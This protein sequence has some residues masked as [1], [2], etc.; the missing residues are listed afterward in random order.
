MSAYLYL[1]SA[2]PERLIISGLTNLILALA[3]FVGLSSLTV[4][5]FA[6]GVISVLFLIICTPL[7]AKWLPAELS[8]LRKRKPWLCV[9]WLAVSIVCVIQ[10]SRLSVFMMNPALPQ[11]SLFPGDTW[12]EQHCCLTAYNEGANLS[13]AGE[14]NI[15]DYGHYNHKQNGFNVDLYHYPP[16]FLLLPLTLQSITGGNF[17]LLRML[18]FSISLLCLMAAIILI[19]YSLEH[20]GKMRMIGMAPLI[21]VSLP[22]LS[23]LQMSNVQ[24][25]IISI[26][27][28]AMVLIIKQTAAGGTLLAMGAAAKIFPGI[29]VFYLLA[30]RKY[31]QVLWTGAIAVVLTV[32]AYLVVGMKPFQAFFE[33]ELPLLSSGEAFARP[34]TKAFAVAR[35]MSPFGIAVKLQWLGVDG[36]SLLT[37]RIIGS[38]YLLFVLGLAYWAARRQPRSATEAVSIWIS[39]LGLGSL[40]SP[41]APANYILVSVIILVCLN[42]ELFRPRTA[43]VI[44]VIICAPFFVD[45]IAPFMTQMLLHLPAQLM[46]IFIPAYV[47]YRAGVLMETRTEVRGQ[48]SESLRRSVMQ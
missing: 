3:L 42:G 48:R 1:S 21:L 4:N 17:L 18:W 30:G 19:I 2:G 23:G 46:A 32:L 7:A 28:I 27:L 43:G 5:I 8:G 25:I 20:K 35:N 40:V 24:I 14:H 37:G 39:L 29:L 36:V 34:F 10:L 9:L 31:K 44:W 6:A 41:F 15:Y 16:T 12:M 26:S 45:R 47:L 38:V 22:V 33:H 11:Y 13:S